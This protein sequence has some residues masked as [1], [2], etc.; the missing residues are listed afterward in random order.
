M[1]VYPSSK[2]YFSS[3]HFS[4]TPTLYPL[5][6]PLFLP[7]DTE[8]AS[9]LGSLL[10]LW[11]P[12]PPLSIS[13]TKA[14]MIFSKCISEIMSLSFL[15]LF[16]EMKYFKTNV[17]LGEHENSSD[18]RYPDKIYFWMRSIL[19]ATNKNQSHC[20]LIGFYVIRRLFHPW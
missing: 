10:S 9:L 8:I 17:R 7:G 14:R 2:P 18:S 5:A 20:L 4:P 11:I 3:I 13:D 15:L 1:C 19:Q 12:Y 16:T 6:R